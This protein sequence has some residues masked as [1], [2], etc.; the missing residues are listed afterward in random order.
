MLK[1][2]NMRLVLITLI[3]FLP[4]FS[5]AQGQGLFRIR[6]GLTE[7]PTDRIPDNVDLP[8]RLNKFLIMKNRLPNEVPAN[9]IVQIG[10][11]E[12]SFT[13]DGEFHE[14]VFSHDVKG[15]LISILDEKRVPQG[16]P[17]FLRRPRGQ[18]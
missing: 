15:L 5:F 8:Q 13:T 1:I 17:F 7:F 11:E 14:I 4:Y 2:K 3:I 10:E 12:H 9:Y 18:R 16:R 6:I